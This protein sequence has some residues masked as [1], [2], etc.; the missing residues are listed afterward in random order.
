[1]TRITIL[2]GCLLLGG[3][4]LQ[5]EDPAPSHPP[6]MEGM[7]CVRAHQYNGRIICDEYLSYTILNQ[8]VPHTVCR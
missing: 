3:C 4:R 2:I 7:A 6:Q 5:M 8:P 1:M